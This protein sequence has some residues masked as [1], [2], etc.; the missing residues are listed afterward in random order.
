[1]Y[2]CW[3]YPINDSSGRHPMPTSPYTWP[4]GQGDIGKFLEGIENSISWEKTHGQIYRIWSGMQSEVY[5]EIPALRRIIMLTPKLGYLR[6][7]TIF[8]QSSKILILTPKPS[9]TIQATLWASYSAV[10]WASLAEKLGDQSVRSLKCLLCIERFQIIS[11][12]SKSIPNATLRNYGSKNTYL[13]ASYILHRISKCS[14][15][16]SWQKSSTAN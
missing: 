6:A 8:R 11:Q 2:L 5:V 16:G 10:V 14:P 9:T 7:R 12:P 4:N 3:R 15:S 1:M 13:K